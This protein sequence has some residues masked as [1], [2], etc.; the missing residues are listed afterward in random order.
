MIE[1]KKEELLKSTPEYEEYSENEAKLTK[2]EM[3]ELGLLSCGCSCGK[4]NGC[5][6]KGGCG[7]KKS[8]CKNRG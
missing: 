5:S 8:C 1:I 4:S 2:E 6:T 7:S 3:K